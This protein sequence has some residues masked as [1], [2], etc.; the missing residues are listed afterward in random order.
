M[1]KPG[2]DVMI[3]VG[4]PKPM[5]GGPGGVPGL[6]PGNK[7]EMDMPKDPMK[8]PGE[9]RMARIEN[10]LAK[11]CEALSIEDDPIEEAMEDQPDPSEGMEDEDDEG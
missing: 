6:T 4:K 10:R 2:L 7:P 8:G 5:K 1:K 3:A 9:D 11:I